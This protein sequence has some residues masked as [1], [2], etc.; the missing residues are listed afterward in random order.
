ME[1]TSIEK[2]KFGSGLFA[3]PSGGPS[4]DLSAIQ[5]GMKPLRDPKGQ[6]GTDMSHDD[7]GH[8]EAAG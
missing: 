8:E 5:E 3:F 4:R 2:K 7:R 6:G 1:V